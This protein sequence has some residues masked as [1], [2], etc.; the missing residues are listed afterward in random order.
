MEVSVL[1]AQDF[2]YQ[3]PYIEYLD[4][5]SAAEHAMEEMLNMGRM[6]LHDALAHLLCLKP[7]QP[8]DAL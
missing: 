7:S 3:M 5:G 4:S 6:K 2:V 8:I 1:Q